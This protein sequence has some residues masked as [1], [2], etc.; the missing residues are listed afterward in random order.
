[1]GVGEHHA[2]ARSEENDELHAAFASTGELR[3]KVKQEKYCGEL[4]TG[5]PFYTFATSGS[6]DDPL[7][8]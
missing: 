6:E 5:C 4:S 8:I 2:G 3:L 7:E 1:M